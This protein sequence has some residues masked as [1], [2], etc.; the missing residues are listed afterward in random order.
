VGRWP[1]KELS[2]SDHFYILIFFSGASIP[3]QNLLDHT[4]KRILET[5]VFESNNIEFERME[6]FGKYGCDG[7][8]G[9]MEY[10]QKPEEN[11]V[12]DDSISETSVFGFYFS[13][14][15]ITGFQMDSEEKITVWSNPKHSSTAYCRPIKF[16]YFK[17]S[18]ENILTEFRQTEREVTK[19]HPFQADVN[20]E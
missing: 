3:V 1:I 19:L 10:M 16:L 20:G 11:A 5:V 4:C 18:K 17:E 7:S 12:V 13:P 8:S 15:V 2:C 6:L 14:L 9:N